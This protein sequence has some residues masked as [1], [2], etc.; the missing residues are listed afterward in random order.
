MRVFFVLPLLLVPIAVA[1]NQTL[2]VS[3]GKSDLSVRSHKWVKAR[4][5]S[6]TVNQNEPAQPAPSLASTASRTARREDRLN[7]S[8]QP[9]EQ[10]LS[11]EARS[12]ALEKIVRESRSLQPKQLDGYSYELNLKNE[13]TK[14]IE[15]VFW[16]YQFI[17]T[18]KTD[19]EGVVRRQFLCGLNLKP[20]KEKEVVVFSLS[21]PSKVVNAQSLGS[22]KQQEERVLINRVEYADGTIWQRKGW[23]FG[24]I[25]LSYLNAMASP[26]T[27]MCRGL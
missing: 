17:D 4:R 11:I 7:D 22:N 18:G 8:G 24:E 13:G 10:P 21:G 19:A 12:A 26:W 15:V 1:N 9:R 6:N 25:R 20:G 3:E 27:E 23:S 2:V 5:V 14:K 16:E